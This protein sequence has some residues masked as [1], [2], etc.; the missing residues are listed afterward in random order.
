MFFLLK[1]KRFG[2]LILPKKKF[3]KYKKRLFIVLDNQKIYV[4]DNLEIY[5]YALDYKKQ[6]VI[7]AKNFGIP[8]RSNIKIF[9][10]KIFLANQDNIIYCVDALTGEKIL[11]I[12]HNKYF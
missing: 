6:K 7:W 9:G 11:G 4:S 1:K 8:F 10:N 3:K 12:R 5:L 2:N